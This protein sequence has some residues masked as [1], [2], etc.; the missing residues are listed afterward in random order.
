M[1]TL[2]HE[3]SQIQA[4]FLTTKGHRRQ[5]RLLQ[6]KGR[7]RKRSQKLILRLSK[8]SRIKVH[9]GNNGREGISETLTATGFGLLL[10]IIFDEVYHCLCL[11]DEGAEAQ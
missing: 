5:N 11:P 8:K 2:S 3:D 6:R 7:G 10:A 9:L 1:E 4:E